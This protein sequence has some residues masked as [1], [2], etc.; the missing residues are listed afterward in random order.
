MARHFSV[1]RRLNQVP[2]SYLLSWNIYIYIYIYSFPSL[3][4]QLVTILKQLIFSLCRAYFEKS[5][6]N[7]VT[8]QISLT[9]TSAKKKREKPARI[10]KQNTQTSQKDFI[11]V[12]HSK[13]VDYRTTI[14]VIVYI[15]YVV[16]KMHGRYWSISLSDYLMTHHC[17]NR[18]IKSFIQ[19]ISMQI[20]DEYA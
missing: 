11:L 17:S 7:L 19:L 3:F 13:S 12:T 20:A 4:S 8:S 9:L 18:S 1:R 5:T 15:Y 6:Q 14:R 10:V 16:E 2:I